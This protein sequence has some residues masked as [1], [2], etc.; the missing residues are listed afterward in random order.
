[1][2]LDR[3][4]VGKGIYAEA[5]ADANR[6]Q[7]GFGA[8]SSCRRS[9][10]GPT[11]CSDRHESITPSRASLLIKINARRPFWQLIESLI[12]GEFREWTVP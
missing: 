8:G 3:S 7:R 12:F 2:A 5:Q 10:G 11:T 6:E 1:M 9:G 4:N